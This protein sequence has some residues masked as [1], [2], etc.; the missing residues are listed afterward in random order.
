MSGNLADLSIRSTD[1][2]NVAAIGIEEDED[3]EGMVIRVAVSGGMLESVVVGL[4][5]VCEI[6]GTISKRG[7]RLRNRSVGISRLTVAR[8]LRDSR[9]WRHLLKQVVSM[10][11]SRIIKRLR[12]SRKYSVASSPPQKMKK[13][14]EDHLAGAELLH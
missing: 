10:V 14:L 7:K 4:S 13:V 2:Q 9:E 12:L 3:G 5:K 8:T 6:L 11:S 1:G